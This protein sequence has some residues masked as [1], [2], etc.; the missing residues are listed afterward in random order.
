MAFILFDPLG[1]LGVLSKL[2]FAKCFTPVNS[3]S[4]AFD[5]AYL[6]HVKHLVPLGTIRDIV[7]VAPFTVLVCIGFSSNSASQYSDETRGYCFGDCWVG[8]CFSTNYCSDDDLNAELNEASVK[9]SS[10][11]PFAK[12][13][14]LMLR[15]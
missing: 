4:L 14:G 12:I 1:C 5:F 9:A 8:L 7:P 11:S 3:S 15:R 2:L 10:K 13:G 6:E